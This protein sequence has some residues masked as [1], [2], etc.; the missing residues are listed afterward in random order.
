M[1][2]IVDLQL[3]SLPELVRARALSQPEKIFLH[4]TRDERAFSYSAFESEIKRAA[5]RLCRAGIGKEDRV[6]IL[7]SNSPEFL[8]F[9]FG[10]M[11]LGAIACPI[12]TQ[13]K[14]Q[15]IAY[16]LQHSSA[17]VCVVSNEL[18]G[19]V[20]AIR[21]SLP[22]LQHVVMAEES[23][24][25]PSE[26]PKAEVDR[27]DGA[28]IIYTS[29]TTGRPK[30][31]L[32][33][34]GNILANAGEIAA[35]LALDARD[36]FYC[37]MPLF[38]VNGLVVS[39]ATSL[40]VGGTLIL[41]ERFSAREFWSAVE[42]YRP[43]TFGS[44]PTMLSNLIYP[45]AEQGWRAIRPCPLR[46]GLCGSAPVPI[47]VMRQFEQRFGCP[48]VEGYGLTECTC[49]ATFNPPGKGRRLG[50]VGR[51]IGNQIRIVDDQDRDLP[52]GR[53]GEVLL[54]GE[55][56]MKGYYKDPFAT[57]EA[58]RGG[59][60]HSGDLGYLDEDGYLYIVDRKSDLI[61]RGGENIYPREIDMVLYS[62][63]GVREAATIG[64][65][66]EKYGE[67]VKSY[68]VLKAGAGA[69]EADLVEFCRARL[70]DYKCPKK[71][72]VVSEIPTS[73]TGKL[74]KKE[75]RARETNFQP[76]T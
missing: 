64:V 39:L 50:S 72:D 52:R 28:M 49:R 4:F 35:W 54:K 20:D 56:V 37:V 53:V 14:P 45:A 27:S 11:D 67:E 24:A 73:A 38:H 68:V 48:I 74:L 65:R 71:I 19:R 1:K 55:N 40:W 5:H 36:R 29:G 69:T 44:V 8:F 30:G 62:H 59:W 31:A 75:L 58:L 3:R 46:F 13:L 21:G 34:H 63:P 6:A 47:E 70:A 23:R 22:E 32:L 42:K 12:N 17:K 10:A 60:L 26:S 61:I 7:V 66:D 43:T 25:E 41:A 15:E 2:S 33:T 51:P 57:G 9:Y 18:V 76:P 16:I